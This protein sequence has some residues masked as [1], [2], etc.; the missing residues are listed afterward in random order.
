[1]EY[2]AWSRRAAAA[3]AL[4]AAA[5][6]V[7][8]FADEWPSTYQKCIVTFAVL[9]AVLIYVLCFAAAF[10]GA[11]SAGMLAAS[12]RPSVFMKVSG[13]VESGPLRCILLGVAAS[14]V[15]VVVLAAIK[16][17]PLLNVV[18]VALWILALWCA[19][20]AVSMALGKWLLFAVNSPKGDMPVWSILV[21]GGILCAVSIVP[22]LGWLAGLLALAAGL[23]GL[24]ASPF[25]GRRSRMQ[26]AM[27]PSGPPAPSDPAPPATPAGR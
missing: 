8:A 16:H 24:I 18:W 20:V 1:M 27:P 17:V 10:A 9:G 19:L 21:G 26:T 6:P 13:T 11:I 12:L 15:A 23:G 4:A 7:A 5:V 25:A 3:A 22:V 2:Q 14:I